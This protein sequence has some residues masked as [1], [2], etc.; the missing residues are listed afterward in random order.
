[1]LA[2]KLLSVQVC[3]GFVENLN[4]DGVR[5]KINNEYVLSGHYEID[6][7]GIRY[8]R[9]QLTFYTNIIKR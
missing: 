1:M 7:A 6:I 5:Q 3:L 8:V 2:T 9:V 4:K